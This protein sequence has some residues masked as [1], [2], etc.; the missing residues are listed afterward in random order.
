MPLLSFFLYLALL[1]LYPT[2]SRK[3]IAAPRKLLPLGLLLHSALFAPVA[4]RTPLPGLFFLREPTSCSPRENF[5]FLSCPLP[6][7]CPPFPAHHRPMCSRFFL[8]F[9]LFGRSTPGP[10]H[11]EIMQRITEKSKQARRNLPGWDGR[12]RA[13]VY[14]LSCLFRV[15]RS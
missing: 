1:S 5:V 11:R 10:S 2:V 15:Y 12:I 8:S 6:S 9:P 4:S 14:F 7:P 13:P 3:R